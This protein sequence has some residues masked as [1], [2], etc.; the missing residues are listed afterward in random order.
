MYVVD[1]SCHLDF[2]IKNDKRL[3]IRKF[4]NVYKRAKYEIKT[5]RSMKRN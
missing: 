5:R 1:Y 4:V 2:Q 3:N